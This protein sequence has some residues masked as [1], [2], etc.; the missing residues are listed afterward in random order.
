[1]NYIITALDAEARALIEHYQLK[2]DNA[3]PYTLYKNE[4]TVLLVCGIGKKNALM[5]VSALLG[6]RRPEE[7]DILINIGICG[8]PQRFKIG[9]TLLIHQI[10]EEK[11]RYYPDI[12]FSHSLQ[13]SSIVCIDHPQ[14]HTTE[15]PVDM[16]SA[17]IFY[18]ASRFFKLHQ[19]AFLKIVSDHFQPE[20]VTKEG[21]VELIRSKVSIIDHMIQSLSAVQSSTPLFTKEERES[22][23]AFKAHF[24]QT[25]SNAL[26][27]ALYFFRLKNGSSPIVLESE[28]PNSKR[29]R[30]VLLEELIATLT[31]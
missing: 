8:A 1:M 9:E 27:D 18:A 21:V 7:N 19:I 28:I 5:S 31:T 2:R 30:S 26:E 6:W 4:T 13:E 29:Q 24:T 3:L 25:Q 16:E 14:S 20:N 17:A 12:L 10:V 23:E 11:R 22:I 15:E